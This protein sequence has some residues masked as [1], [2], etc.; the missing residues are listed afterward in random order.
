MISV[1]RFLLSAGER[2]RSHREDTTIPTQWR[3]GGYLAREGRK[4]TNT[5]DGGRDWGGYQEKDNTTIEGHREDTTIP[6]QWSEGGRIPRPGRIPT[7][8]GRRKDIKG[9]IPTRWREGEIEGGY[10]KRRITTLLEKGIPR[11]PSGDS[12][13]CMYTSY[14]NIL[15]K[16][17]WY[18]ASWKWCFRIS[19]WILWD[20][21]EV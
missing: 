9:R 16:S 12:Q 3:E 21:K 19:S 1:G 2:G 5:V 18:P 10:T 15:E 6:T 7:L 14:Q 8:W 17:T 13:G 11:E 20:S 4:D